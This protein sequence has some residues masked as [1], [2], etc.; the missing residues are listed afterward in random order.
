MDFFVA[1]KYSNAATATILQS[2][3]P[4]VIVIITSI[5]SRKLP[6]KT[7]FLALIF[8]FVGAFFSYYPWQI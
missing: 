6:S 3:A 4:F 7:V 5:T 1:V 2:L 8:A